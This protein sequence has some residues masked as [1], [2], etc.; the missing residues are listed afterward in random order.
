MVIFIRIKEIKKN[1]PISL[2]FCKK[3]KHVQIAEII[4]PVK[5]FSN[6]LWQTSV[7][8]TNFLIFEQLLKQYKKFFK[9]KAKV[10][11]IACNDGSFL[12]FLKKN[13][14]VYS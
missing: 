13:L 8:K 7:S 2:N 4:N 11:E 12:K 3:C 5:L 6:Y 10:L 9:N 14:I 1:S